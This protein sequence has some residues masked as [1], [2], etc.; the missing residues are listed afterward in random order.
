MYKSKSGIP[1]RKAPVEM[2]ERSSYLKEV[3]PDSSFHAVIT[4][5]NKKGFVYGQPV[6]NS[7]RP[8]DRVWCVV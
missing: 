3:W 7:K 4:W 8:S 1:G 2:K 5:V 6:A